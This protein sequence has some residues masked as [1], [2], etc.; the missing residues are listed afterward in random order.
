MIEDIFL[1]VTAYDWLML[2]LFLLILSQIA[3]HYYLAWLSLAVLCACLVKAFFPDISW[4]WQLISL[5]LSSFFL[6]ALGFE[7]RHRLNPK[8]VRKFKNPLKRSQKTEK[9]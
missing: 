9:G 3:E 2:G 1:R 4:Q 5:G 7:L 6:L 8:I